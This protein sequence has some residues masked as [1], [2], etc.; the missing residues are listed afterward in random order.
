MTINAVSTYLKY[1][2]L[3]MAAE[4]LLEDPESFSSQLTTGNNRSSKFTN[5][6]ADQFVQD[7]KVVAYQPNTST[8]FSATL[9]QCLVDDPARGL[10]KGELALSFRSTEFVDDAVRD[11]QAT[12]A[13]E[14]SQYGWAF[15][16]IADMK[17]WVDGLYTSGKITTDKQLTVT[18]YS[19]GGHLATA[20]NM[21][22]PGDANATY[23][24]N[25]AGVGT[26]TTSVSLSSTIVQ[27]DQRR[28]AGNDLS[29][30][31]TDA[32]VRNMY[33][34]LRGVLQGG[35]LVT[36]SQIAAANAL[37][38]G[39]SQP[40]VPQTWG[41]EAKML[42]DALN[43]I[44]TIQAEAARIGV[45]PLS[46]GSG[47]SGPFV[48][49]DAT[50]VEAT[51]LNYQLAVL[52]AARNTA[53][54]GAIS[55]GAQAY[56]GRQQG[57]YTFANFYD[58][59]G[60]TSPSAVSN[61]Q[62]HYGLATPVFIEDQPLWRGDI[63][64]D[65]AK[66]SLAY[67]DVKLLDNNFSR[68]DFGDTHSLVL[69]VDSLSVQNVLA[70]LDPTVSGETLVAILQSASNAKAESGVGTNNQGKAEGDVLEHVVDALTK[71]LKDPA[72]TPIDTAQQM[73]GG[74]WAAID[75]RN[76]FYQKLKAVTGSAGFQALSGKVT[77]SPSSIGL[78]TSARNSFS[79]LASLLTLSPLALTATDTNSQ[80]ILDG[81]MQSV[82]G[83]T[84]AAW[85]LDKSMAQSQ[86]EAGAETFT[87]RWMAD[88]SLLLQT[89]MTR[90]TI[91]AAS[92]ATISLPSLADNTI[93]TDATSTTL[94]FAT[95][96]K[97]P[98]S[99]DWYT[100]ITFGAQSAETINGNL[101]ADRLYGGG[102]ADTINGQG[103]DD[104]L[105]GNIGTDGLNGGA[106]N[107][108]LL[109]GSG[110]DILDGGLDA[111][112]LKGGQ[113]LDTYVFSGAW[114]HDTITDSDGSGTLQV[115]GFA[116]GLP[117][118]KRVAPN[119]YESSDGRVTYVLAPTGSGNRLDIRITGR[120]DTIAILNWSTTNS[121][122]ITL[123]EDITPPT[124]TNTLVADF[125]KAT[126]GSTYLTTA[127]GYVAGAA[128]PGAADIVLGGSAS[129]SLAGLLGNDGLY[130]ADGDD[131]LD[132]GDGS[133][134]L[135][136][137]TGADTLLGGAAADIIFGSA[138][139]G[140]STPTSVNFTS[141]GSSGEE[142]ARGFSWVAYRGTSPRIQLDAQ[143]RPIYTLR[144]M[145]V[146]GAIVSPGWVQGGQ[147]MVETEGN[148]ID[149]GAG[150]DYIAAGT[151]ADTV[152]GGL[153]DDDILGM[154][155]ADVLFGD[156]GAD[157]IWGDGFQGSEA[158]VFTPL[159]R[160]GNDILVGGA[161]NDALV[162]Q[163]GDDELYGGSEDDALWGDDPSLIDTPASVAT[164]AHHFQLLQASTTTRHAWRRCDFACLRV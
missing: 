101:A 73:D 29:T 139:G 20:F 7:W 87:D 111:D 123:D 17:N 110:A 143:G 161:G 22:F 136:G 35:A 122:G 16:Q 151:G 148:V 116:A 155:G 32:D 160:H 125:A 66:T 38:Q 119:T 43:R 150:N 154:D 39:K 53:A 77:I 23:T 121:L 55:N 8:G 75:A 46:S 157:F 96:T 11:N 138:V 133:D 5:V 64:G 102:G 65:A 41:T 128:E 40:N 163:G 153:D 51:D 83:D 92:T 9:F 12:N 86:R 145:S 76:V 62:L 126:S 89:A 91:N 10:V 6:I 149:G 56:L 42:L 115:E 78:Q 144:Q 31:F 98:P 70:T 164:S 141:P 61:S 2:N 117:Q 100:R 88:R 106:G 107:D 4:A 82:W 52:M 71:L 140:I 48:P 15:G 49:V 30:L 84:Y 3:Q 57:P 146:G 147:T 24:F 142:V 27:F 36:D 109:G 19:L 113:G 158:S 79:A 81:V 156:A 21:L 44:R 104:Y 85:Q 97:T 114:G 54:V 95:R 37:A 14:I 108:T 127:G 34:S 74:T 47:Q 120:S 1:A 90:N 162:G 59:Y 13:M 72:A 137:G 18:G 25:G 99:S 93:F 45:P 112:L 80:S 60:D 69:L 129:D 124:T 50:Q 103:G 63:L 118:G 130:G 58:V 134:L 26:T 33:T 28:G 94:I 131:V 132:G 152:H 67:W 159:E 105:E 135:L 68:N